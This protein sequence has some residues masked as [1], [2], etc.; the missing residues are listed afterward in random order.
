MA[1]RLTRVT[2]WSAGLVVA[3][4]QPSRTEVPWAAKPVTGMASAASI[5]PPL[6]SAN[7]AELIRQDRDAR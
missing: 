5:D 7:S 1:E 3:G 6:A 2:A 4:C